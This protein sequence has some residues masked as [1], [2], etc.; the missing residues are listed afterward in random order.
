LIR[1]RPSSTA[2]VSVLANQA[3]LE[4][5][6]GRGDRG[7]AL[8]TSA[9]VVADEIGADRQRAEVLVT[10]GSAEVANGHVTDGLAA[11]E[12]GIELARQEHPV[13]ELRG[14]NN[15]GSYFAAFGRL[16][17]AAEQRALALT[18]AERLGVSF[19]ARWQQVER[20]FH[21]YWSGNWERALDT[22]NGV[23]ALAE[24]GDTHL[25]DVGARWTRSA[26]AVARGDLVTAGREADLALEFAR[27]SA[28]PQT[29]APLLAWHA[30]FLAE[31]GD[32]EGA[33][34][35]AE[36]LLSSVSTDSIEFWASGI[37]VALELVGRGERFPPAPPHDAFRPWWDAG[38]ALASGRYQEAADRYREIGSLPDE[39]WARL[40]AGR[41]LFNEGRRADATSELERSLAFWRSV[42]ATR[43]VRQAEELLGAD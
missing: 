43:Y 36:E 42:G 2:K 16:S 18:G 26:L 40:R 17:E 6:Q 19:Y 11:L 21:D 29:L 41:A 12:R 15:L 4:F 38:A 30:R 14:R 1:D 9:F 31:T 39:A 34:M 35:E 23:L 25:M 3:R 10:L 33:T 13:E 28:D 8:A 37:A 24:A 7:V 20:I 32:A 5:I 27:D 22:A